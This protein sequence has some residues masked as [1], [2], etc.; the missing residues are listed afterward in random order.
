MK[1]IILIAL[2]LTACSTPPAT[3]SAEALKGTAFVDAW[4]AIVAAYTSTPEATPTHEPTNTP[5]PTATV[6]DTNTPKATATETSTPK[7]TTPPQQTAKSD[8]FYLIGIDISPGVWRSNGSGDRCYWEVTTKTGDVI[9]NHFGLAGG[10]A[11]IPAD[12][13]QISFE[14]CGT[15]TFL[16]P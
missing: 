14:R 15:W 11:Y 6:G 12:G 7:P 3:L 9:S 10:T 16:S 5:R 1:K 8:G 2:L 4:T 13:F